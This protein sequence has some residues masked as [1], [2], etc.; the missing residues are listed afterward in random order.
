MYWVRA[1]W[2]ISWCFNRARTSYSGQLPHMSLALIMVWIWSTVARITHWTRVTFGEGRSSALDG[3]AELGR[4]DRSLGLWSWRWK[5]FPCS[6]FTLWP[7]PSMVWTASSFCAIMP[8]LTMAYNL[9]SKIA[10]WTLWAKRHPSPFKLVF[11]GT[12]SYH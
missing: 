11:S 1:P 9:E 8:C 10:D 4:A 6:C 7:L 5:L 3:K 12:W 2:C